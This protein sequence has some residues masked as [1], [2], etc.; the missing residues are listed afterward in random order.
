MGG[1]CCVA[2][3]LVTFADEAIRGVNFGSRLTSTRKRF[4]SW[5]RK[6]HC[7][8]CST[9]LGRAAQVPAA[10]QRQ[11]HCPQSHSERKAAS[12]AT[13]LAPAAVP[14][15]AGDCCTTAPGPISR[16]HPAREPLLIASRARAC[17]TDV[18]DDHRYRLA[19]DRPLLRK[20]YRTIGPLQRTVL[21][22]HRPAIIFGIGDHRGGSMPH[23]PWCGF[24][25]R[26]EE[27]KAMFAATWRVWLKI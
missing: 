2:S 22:F 15:L 14:H 19:N 21:A 10:L 4:A 13:L 9:P 8:A 5:G 3:A 26:R 1:Q 23:L 17:R 16:P 18:M 24:C 12:S 20:A 7:C 11:A 27:A 25:A 6:A